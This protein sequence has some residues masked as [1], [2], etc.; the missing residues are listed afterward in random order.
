M[1]S[2]RH[3]SAQHPG[4][5]IRQPHRRQKIGGEQLG[6]DASVDLVGLDLGLGDRPRLARV[7]HHDT[8]NE[9]R[10]QHRDRVAVP[11][12]LERDLVIRSQRA[13]PL[14]QRLGRDSDLPLVS[15][16]AVLDDG[17]LRKCAVHIHPDRS[18][19]LLLARGCVRG[20]AG[21][22]DNYGLAL[23][24]H[25]GRSQGRPSTNASSRLMEYSGL[26]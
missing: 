11:R 22:N 6:Q 24:A 16:Q 23:A 10:E 7:G 4:A 2:P 12:R 17:D 9:R 15:A 1:G 25:S 21:R 26:P 13:R 3:L 14:A 5:V 19:R 20:T 18:H 8:S